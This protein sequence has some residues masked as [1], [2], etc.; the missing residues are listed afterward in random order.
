[1]LYELLPLRVSCRNANFLSFVPITTLSGY[2]KSLIASPSLKNSGLETTENFFL[3][4]FLDRIFSIS[5]P[6]VTG[7]VDFVIIILNLSI[8]ED[9]YTNTLNIVSLYIEKNACNEIASC[10]F[11]ALY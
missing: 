5:S 7:I 8:E 2:I 10:D 3:L 11:D 4:F 9:I 6:V 1:M